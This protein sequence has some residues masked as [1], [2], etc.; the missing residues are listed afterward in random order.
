MAAWHGVVAWTLILALAAQSGCGGGAHALTRDE[1]TD[2]EPAESYVVTLVSGE[3]L[4]FIALHLEGD[5]LRGTERVTEETLV[6]EGDQARTTVSNR[7][8]E[9]SLP[10]GEVAKVEADRGENRLEG[11]A[12]IAAG[13]ILAGAVLFLILSQ[14]SDEPPPDDGGKVP[15]GT[16]PGTGR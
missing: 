1:L 6:G 5:V 8:Q 2:P 9:R 16:K 10:W 15:P 4:T 3:V 14:S 12:W 11:G 7:Y 13:S